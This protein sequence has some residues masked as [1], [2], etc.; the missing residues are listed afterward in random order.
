MEPETHP[1]D[2]R[3]EA[4]ATLRSAAMRLR[5]IVGPEVRVELEYRDTVLT[6]TA[7]RP[8]GIMTLFATEDYVGAHWPGDADGVVRFAEARMQSW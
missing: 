3:R 4:I 2:H 6:I 8:Q 1:Q 7:P 5:E